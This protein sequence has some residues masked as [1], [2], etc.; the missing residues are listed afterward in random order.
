MCC[1]PVLEFPRY[2]GEYGD[3][4]H[5]EVVKVVTM[6]DPNDIVFAAASFA[7]R[8]HRH[9]KRKDDTTPYVSHVFRVC[10]VVRHVF[11]FDDPKMLAAALLHDTIEDTDTDYDNVFDEFGKEIADWVS[12]LTKEKRW[13]EEKR[14]AL[15]AE[16]LRASPWQVKVIK[17]ADQYDNLA[18]CTSRDKA[19]QSKT[20]DKVRFYLKAVRD[21]LPLE[22]ENALRL[23]EE[24]LAM[25]EKTL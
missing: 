7:A 4:L 18:D 23:V 13:Q 2:C 19:G 20:A 25:L 11:G 8:A 12:A 5:Q 21:G 15:Y 22:G 1:L 16:T 17:L 9:Q 14:E 6:P 10:L 3:R 24:K